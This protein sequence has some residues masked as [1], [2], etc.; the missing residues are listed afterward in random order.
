[1]ALAI[2]CDELLRTGQVANQSA[3]AEYTQ[4]TPARMT[5][6]LTLLNLAPD[7]QEK[8]VRRIAIEMDWVPQEKQWQFILGESMPLK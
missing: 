7:I 4:I 6:I 3:L 8:D 1:M 5:Q 2:H